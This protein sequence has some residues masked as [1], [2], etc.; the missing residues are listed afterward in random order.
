MRQAGIDKAERA[1]NKDVTEYFMT[2]MAKGREVHL[3][4]KTRRGFHF[5]RSVRTRRGLCHTL[6]SAVLG[7]HPGLSTHRKPRLRVGTLA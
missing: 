7:W 5:T 3:S 4:A 6:R 2:L 1:F